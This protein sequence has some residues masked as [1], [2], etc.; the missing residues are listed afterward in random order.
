VSALVQGGWTIKLIA[1]DSVR[2]RGALR[3]A[4]KILTGSFPQLACD[5]RK[6]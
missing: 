1:A 5:P 3:A 4:R 6:L 2:L